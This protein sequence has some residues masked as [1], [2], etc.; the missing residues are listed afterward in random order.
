[1]TTQSHRSAFRCAESAVIGRV[2]AGVTP[3]D[4]T[5][6]YL[7]HLG[8]SALLGAGVSTGDHVGI[9]GLGVLGMGAMACASLAGARVSGFSAQ[10]VGL[11]LIRD[12]GGELAFQKDHPAVAD[13]YSDHIGRAGAD[14]VILTS[15][16]WEDYLLS[17][18][19]LRKR[20]TLV[21]LGFPGRARDP[22]PFN[23]LDSQYFYDKQLRI[24]SSNWS[25]ERD[26]SPDRQS[27][28]RRRN[29]EFLLHTIAGG[30]LPARQMLSGESQWTDLATVYERLSARTSGELSHLL[31]WRE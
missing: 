5:T 7:F 6:T 14:L 21:V 20:G 31:N 2:P 29:C 13:Q 8:Y 25:S 12:F 18:K 4:A 26:A 27:D 24:Q 1:M 30:R 23:P 22:A 16:R 10:D 28:I 3:G 15:D 11:D 17:L 19:L 9:V